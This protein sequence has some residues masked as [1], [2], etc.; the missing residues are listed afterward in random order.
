[1]DL[2]DSGNGE[3][4]GA[5]DAAPAGPSDEHGALSSRH[6]PWS[7][8]HRVNIRVSVP[9]I[10]GRYYLSIVAGK[11]RRS[12]Q[13]RAAEKR[14]H[15]LNTIGNVIFLSAVGIIVGLALMTLMQA[16]MLIVFEKLAILK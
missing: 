14:K 1:M 9:L 15:P 5:A 3:P 7:S 8:N 13:R 16:G 10:F 2:F 12:E 11:E 4:A 6:R